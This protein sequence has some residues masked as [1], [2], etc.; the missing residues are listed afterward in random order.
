MSLAVARTAWIPAFAGML[1]FLGFVSGP[2][3]T[4][5][6]PPAKPT[7]ACASR[8]FDGAA[9]TVCGYTPG[10]DR[11]TLAW[12]D[13]HGQALRGFKA[14]KASL[15]AKEAAKVRFAMNAGMFGEA[16]EPIG[17]YVANSKPLV[18]LNT[19]D[20]SGNFYM[21]PNG[22]FWLDRAKRPHVSTAG[23]YAAAKPKAAWATQSGPMLVI[24]GQLHSQI[25]EDGPS[26]NIR[27]GVGAGCPDGAALFVISDDAVSFGKLARFFRDGLKC[28]DALYFDGSVS[29]LWRPE[30]D[31]LD[32]ARALGPLVVV[33]R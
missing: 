28:R 1:G 18:R 10:R 26:R 19:R 9:F 31:R 20:A 21:K 15:G 29:S 16:G 22:V 12:K 11:L 30:A 17:L 24:A 7:P 6:K 27:N 14:L 8:A 25:V 2:S 3:P 4:A 13:K 33:S 32:E 5:A 23:A